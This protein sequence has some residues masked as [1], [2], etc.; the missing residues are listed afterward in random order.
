VNKLLFVYLSLVP[1]MWMYVSYSMWLTGIVTIIGI[2][3][4]LVFPKYY[5]QIALMLG[6]I[7]LL[8]IIMAGFLYYPSITFIIFPSQSAIG[9]IAIT[10]GAIITIYGIVKK[11]K[12]KR[13]HQN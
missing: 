10:C 1:P 2:V 5:R 9:L 7:G 11:E 12:Q 8:Q 3:T 4:F 13:T 6:I